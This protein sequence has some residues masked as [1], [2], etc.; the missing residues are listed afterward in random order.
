MKANAAAQ[1]YYDSVAQL[2]AGWGV[3]FVKVDCISKPYQADEI[4]M[5]RAALEKT[6]RPMVL[7]LSPGPTPVE[8]ADDVRKF[9][10]LWRISDD[11]WD[12]WL[13]PE[14]ETFPAGLVRQ[15]D[16]AAAWAPHIQVGSL[17]GCGHAALRVSGAE[18]RVGVR[19]GCRG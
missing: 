6:G 13:G 4:R 2:Y 19:R 3:D 1:A 10:E 17:A 18:A 11:M 9:A 16:R 8:E 14:G 7:S 5:M 12:T 15:F